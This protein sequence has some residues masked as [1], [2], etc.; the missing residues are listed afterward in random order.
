[1]WG[2]SEGQISAFFLPFG[3]GAIMLFAV[4]M[5]TELALKARIGKRGTAMLLLVMTFGLSSFMAKVLV[6]QWLQL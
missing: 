2:L 1:M 4:I 3:I 5:M 6:Q